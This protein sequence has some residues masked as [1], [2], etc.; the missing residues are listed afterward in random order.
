VSGRSEE[1]HRKL[2]GAVRQRGNG[3]AK[4]NKL[5]CVSQTVICVESGK[6]RPPNCF[7]ADGALSARTTKILHC[8]DAQL[9]AGV[10]SS[11][12]VQF[13]ELPFAL[14]FSVWASFTCPNAFWYAS[15]T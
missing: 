1:N 4:G 6:K 11:V 3:K 7:T 10:M 8:C 15:C 9:E 13:P 12:A 2:A 14:L 5:R